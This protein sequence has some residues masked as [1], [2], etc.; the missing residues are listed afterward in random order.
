MGQA[1]NL[2]NL[3]FLQVWLPAKKKER[4]TAIKA[5]TNDDA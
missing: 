5:A 4:K 3:N 1:L 2:R